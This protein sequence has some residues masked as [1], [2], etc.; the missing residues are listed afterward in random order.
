MTVIVFWLKIFKAYKPNMMMPAKKNR[1]ILVSLIK[2]SVK[3]TANSG[4]KTASTIKDTWVALFITAE[5]M[6]KPFFIVSTIQSVKIGVCK[7][8][9][10]ENSSSE[11][12]MT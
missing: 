2:E 4:S 5:G 6:E 11:C 12:L 10:H 8:R 3:G 9:K 7:E 1:A